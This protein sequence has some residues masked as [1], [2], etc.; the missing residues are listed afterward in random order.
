MMTNLYFLFVLENYFFIVAP[1]KQTCRKHSSFSSLSDG[2]SNHS[3]L[4]CVTVTAALSKVDLEDSCYEYNSYCGEERQKDQKSRFG[5]VCVPPNA[6]FSG[7]CVCFLFITN[8]L[9]LD[10]F[11]VVMVSRCLGCEKKN[12]TVQMQ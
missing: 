9:E 7:M 11:H 8:K 5:K 12:Q 10:S 4:L 6:S 1:S 3:L 2:S